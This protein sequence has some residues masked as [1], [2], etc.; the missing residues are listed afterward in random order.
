[1][2]EVGDELWDQHESPSADPTVQPD[3]PAEQQEDVDEDE[4]D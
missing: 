1:L 4:D 3:T 2:E